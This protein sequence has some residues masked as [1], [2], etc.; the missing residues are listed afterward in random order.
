MGGVVLRQRGE[1]RAVG[2]PEIELDA[3]DVAILTGH[4]LSALRRAGALAVVVDLDRREVFGTAVRG[5]GQGLPRRLRIEGELVSFDRT[6]DALR[7]PGKGWRAIS[8][9]N[10]QA[11]RFAV[12][13]VGECLADL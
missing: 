8:G 10:F 7:D 4:P 12:E 3:E 2:R 13:G 1:G 6:R 11:K 9:A 5:L